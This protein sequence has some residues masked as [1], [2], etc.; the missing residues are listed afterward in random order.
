[1]K[2]VHYNVTRLVNEQMK[3]DVKNALNKVD[4][5]QIVNVDMGRSTIEVG[6]NES[7]DESRI[8]ESIEQTGC[9]IK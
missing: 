1:M 8:K 2:R 6:Y 7:I 3:N 4:G 9:I 5:V